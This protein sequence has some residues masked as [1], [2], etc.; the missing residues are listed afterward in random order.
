MTRDLL[1]R[2]AFWAL[3]FGSM[4]FTVLTVTPVLLVSV[5]GG[6]FF[7]HPDILLIVSKLVA[8]WAAIGFVIAFI[9]ADEANESGN[10]RIEELAVLEHKGHLLMQVN[11]VSMLI[12]WATFIDRAFGPRPA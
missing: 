8:C 11:L 3:F 1:W 7:L 6:H 4:V 5:Y 12:A 9:L 10:A 2:R